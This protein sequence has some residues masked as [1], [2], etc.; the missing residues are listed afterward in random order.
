VIN[1]QLSVRNEIFFFLSLLL[2]SCEVVTPHPE[3]INDSVANEKNIECECKAHT[4]DLNITLSVIR[5]SPEAE[6]ENVEL[7]QPILT[8]E[9]RNLNKGSTVFVD[10]DINQNDGEV[11]MCVGCNDDI[12][13][14]KQDDLNVQIEIDPLTGEYDIIIRDFQLE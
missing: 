11:D 1:I 10:S 8:G 9:T 14:E 6:E 5:S 4:I 3:I 13:L 12:E 7:T 2:L